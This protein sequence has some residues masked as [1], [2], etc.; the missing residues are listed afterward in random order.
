MLTHLSFSGSIECTIRIRLFIDKRGR[1]SPMSTLKERDLSYILHPATPIH[2]HLRNGPRIIESGKGLFIKDA[3]GNEFLDGVA[4]LWCVN[5]GYGRTELATAMAK[6]TED[7]G[8]YHTFTSMS[9]TP[10]IELAEYLINATDG[11]FSKV[12]FGTSGSDANDTLIKLVWY[13]N[14]LRGK[15][16]KRKI[17]ARHK[18]YHGTSSSTVSLT[19]LPSF[20]KGFGLPFPYALHMDNPDFYRNGKPGETEEAFSQRLAS[21][22]EQLIL[23]E[24]ADTIGAFIAE[25]VMAAGGIIPP[26]K[27]YFQA[28]S[29]VLKK[30]D[31]LMI[32]DEVVCGFG[33]LGSVFGHKHYNYKPDMMSCAKGLTSGYFPLSASFISEEIWQVLVNGASEMGNFSHGYTYS[34]HPVGAAVALANLAIIEKE[35]LIDNAK[36]IGQYLHEQLKSRFLN[37]PHVAEIRGEGLIAAVQLVLDKDNKKFFSPTVKIANRI[38]KESLGEN[39]I[40]RP[41]P[42]VDSVAFSPPLTVNESDIDDILNRFEQGLNKAVRQL[43]NADLNLD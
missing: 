29:A 24:G 19:G 18:A 16:S 17:I 42:S 38:T 27:G 23:A 5:V 4:G 6:A 34:G 7:L 43:T 12:F 20:H 26:S 35:K 22:L 15:P 3:E 8:F 39:L 11:V 1:R 9:N 33:R 37:H 14:Y 40:L 31:I 21:Q 36:T 32:A 2:E 41:L 25:P 13:Y 30:Y 28:I 10:Q